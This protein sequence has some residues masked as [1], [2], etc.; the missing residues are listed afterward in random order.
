MKKRQT[1][2][3]RLALALSSVLFVPMVKAESVLEL[4]TSHGCYSCPPAE[5]LFNE[6]AGQNESL[7]ALEYHVDYWNSLVYGSA[8]KWED[9]FSKPAYSERQRLYNFRELK[10]RQGVYTPQAV[11]NGKYAAVGSNRRQVTAA[12]A[13]PLDG[14]V[15]VDVVTQNNQY[16]INVHNVNDDAS[17]SEAQVWVVRFIRSVTT[18]ITSGENKGKTLENHNVVVSAESV[19]SVPKA[20]SVQFTASIDSDPNRGCAILVQDGF[21]SPI[22]AASKCPG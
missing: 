14:G 10:G 2:T 3:V 19:G 16:V 20:D 13:E 6:L 11:I 1:L 5:A 8:G 9:P 7:I 18:D 15:T 22:L 21:Q 4:F 12:V 17:A